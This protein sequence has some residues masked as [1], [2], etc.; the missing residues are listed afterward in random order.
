[1][2]SE[3]NEIETEQD[4]MKPKW[5]VTEMVR[6]EGSVEWNETWTEQILEQVES[7]SCLLQYIYSFCFTHNC[8]NNFIVQATADAGL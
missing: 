6:D 2:I 8:Q 3:R 4:I 1:M 5:F 7:H